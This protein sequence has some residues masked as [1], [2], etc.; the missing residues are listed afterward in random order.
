LTVW[1]EACWM[2]TSSKNGVSALELQ[3]ALEIG[4]YATAWAMLQRL[5]AVVVRD[6][7]E[8]LAGTVEVDETFVGGK[9]RG[10][11]LGRSPGTKKTL[12]VVAVETRGTS[13]GRVRLQAVPDAS[14]ASL[15]PFIRKN[16]EPDSIVVTDGW[17]PYKQITRHGYHHL[18]NSH[19]LAVATGVDLDDLTPA[20]HRVASLLKRWLLGTH[21]G[22]ARAEHL[23]G[24]LDEFAFR[25]NR[26]RSASRGLLF[27]RLLQLAVDHD[28]VR[29]Q[30]LVANPQP[31]ND[32]T[33]VKRTGRTAN[34]PPSLERSSPDRP[35]RTEPDGPL[36]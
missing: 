5:R 30:H 3:R 4:S 25:F 18:P 15:V 19:R 33:T 17:H 14:G 2:F 24:Y 35:W 8:P 34:H 11:A 21:Q 29:Y 16:I 9:E 7:R 10:K 6:G 32:A 13:L 20:V 36:T 12:V 1:F 23:Q 22:A 26:R 28:P 31:K 27:L